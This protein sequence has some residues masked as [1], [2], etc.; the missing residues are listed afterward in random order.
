MT[1]KCAILSFTRGIDSILQQIQESKDKG[2]TLVEFRL[3][4]FLNY[5]PPV[6]EAPPAGETDAGSSDA[7]GET[8]E[9]TSSDTSDETAET[10]SSDDG[11]ES[12]ET[13]SSDTG[14]ETAETTS[15]DAGSG[16]VETTSPDA[17][18]KDAGK[19]II[20]IE[21]TDSTE[22][23]LLEP[24]P[25][26]EGKEDAGISEDV[27]ETIEIFKPDVTHLEG[28]I[29]ESV[30]PVLVTLRA[31]G[32]G[33]TFAGG[34][35]EKVPIFRKILEYSPAYLELELDDIEKS[36][37]LKEMV[38]QAKERNIKTVI[39]TYNIDECF[40]EDEIEDIG[41]ATDGIDGDVLRIC[42]PVTT[43]TSLANLFASSYGLKK[44]GKVY[45]YFGMG[46]L[47]HKCSIYAPLM[48]SVIAYCTLA[49]KKKV[50]D[51]VMSIDSLNEQWDV[52][53]GKWR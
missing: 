26:Q 27:T 2:A 17:G 30:L 48:G 40:S 49:K 13:T 34:P 4:E 9:T 15:S 22:A 41:Y 21:P 14:G 45:S 39:S 28:I 7:S 51:G 36:G 33:G 3:D 43:F 1:L 37:D 23:A 35:E 20:E 18:K 38:A 42:C 46:K 53:L 5:T 10:T 11:S 52:L 29:R 31:G 47:G 32:S 8:A 6:V 50:E 19:E 44:K 16:A 12:A 24:V 25:V